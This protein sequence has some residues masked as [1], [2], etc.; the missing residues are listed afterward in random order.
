MLFIR[1]EPLKTLFGSQH[2]NGH[3][4]ETLRRRRWSGSGVGV[5]VGG[6]GSGYLVVPLLRGEDNVVRAQHDS[7]PLHRHRHQR[8]HYSL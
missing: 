8:L 7:P 1:C 5:I 2:H 6:G 3:D 4:L